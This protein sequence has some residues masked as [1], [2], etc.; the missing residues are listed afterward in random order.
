LD[1]GSGGQCIL[2][3]KEQRDATSG[4]ATVDDG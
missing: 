3:V 1:G 2:K 4:T